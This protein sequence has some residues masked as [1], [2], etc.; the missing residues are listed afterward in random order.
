M[1]LEG[2]RT[3]ILAVAAL[4]ALL[5]IPAHAGSIQRDGF[6]FP[7]EGTLEIVVFRPDV[8]VGSMKVGGISEPNA[9][10]TD[11]ARENIRTA[12]QSRA[13]TFNARVSFV[14]ELE[15]DNAQLLNDYRSL[16]EAVSSSVFQHITAG[17]RLATKMRE[18]KVGDGRRARLDIGAGGKRPKAGS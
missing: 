15:G 10:W 7:P 1:L 4:V 14:D 17:D 18:V 3:A 2:V 12:L 13:A 11:Q 16:F 6:E 9:E 8:H 5:A